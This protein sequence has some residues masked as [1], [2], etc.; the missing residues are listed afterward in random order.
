MTSPATSP[1]ERAIAGQGAPDQL[2]VLER[3]CADGGAVDH[4]PFEIPIG[5]A[6]VPVA[7]RVLGPV[8]ELEATAEYAA[9]LRAAAPA[10]AELLTDWLSTDVAE[11]MRA[12]CYLARACRDPS[13]TSRPA[14]PPAVWW[15][16]A[17][18]GPVI[19]WLWA[20]YADLVVAHD[21]YG[22]ELVITDARDL[23]ALALAVEKKS[24]APL[25]ALGPWRQARLLLTLADQLAASRTPSSSAGSDGSAS[26]TPATES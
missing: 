19:V 22:G 11:G 2:T 20:E 6:R 1:L 13:D 25:V 18:T 3:A 21:P 8:E 9:R 26:P 23:A 4:R 14:G 7:M 17:I 5:A 24:P 10:G 16:K 12:R 15:D